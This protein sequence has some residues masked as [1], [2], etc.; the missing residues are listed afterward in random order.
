MLKVFGLLARG[1]SGWLRSLRAV[2]LL[3]FDAA[4]VDLLAVAVP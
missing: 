4:R 1:G 2:W 3:H